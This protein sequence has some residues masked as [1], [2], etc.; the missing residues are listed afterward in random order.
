MTLAR[1]APA[2]QRDTSGVALM[3]FAFAAP[4]LLT[5][6]MYGMNLADL[7]V[8]QLKLNQ[9]ALNL[10]DNASRVGSNS[11]LSTQQLREVDIADV[12]QA[13]KTQGQS[14][15]LLANG[16][17]ILSSL[18]KDSS[19]TQR[20]HWQRCFGSKTG[21]TYESHYG[22]ALNADG[23]TATGNSGPSGTNGM[24]NTGAKVHA[25]TNNSGVMFVEIN[26]RYTPMFTWVS[27]AQ[28]LRFVAS[29]VVRDPRDFKQVYA[30]TGVTAQYCGY[31]TQVSP[32]A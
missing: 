28:D 15:N 10:A 17:V 31:T 22:Q 21:T 6:S 19:G 29:F 3:E 24:G 18:E 20:L 14:L 11:N 7:A 1:F 25:P 8:T 4:I 23:S 13:A 5:L 26:Y 32:A 30:S 27:S 16:R 9:I 12:F 2:L